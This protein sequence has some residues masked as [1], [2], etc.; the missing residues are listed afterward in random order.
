M[1]KR[2]VV[3]GINDYSRQVP[4]WPDLDFC[5]ADAGAVHHLLLD[6][7]GFDPAGI[8]LLTDQAA[9]SANIRR[10]LAHMIACSEP[11]DVAFFYYSGHG[12]LHPGSTA[13]TYYQ[14]IAPATGR[15]IT[16]WDVAQAVDRLGPSEVNVT[17]MMD[18]CHSG[19]MGDVTPQG[20]AAKTAALTQDALAAV[21][22]SMRKVIPFGIGLADPETLSNNIV[23]VL[24]A[25]GAVACYTEEA[26]REFVTAAKALQYSACRW[27]ETAA[28]DGIVEH[29]YLTKALID[30]VDSCPF[31]ISNVALHS[32]LHAK[33]VQLSGDDQSPVMRGQANRADDTFLAPF[34]DSR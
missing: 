6:S 29:G 15:Y 22:S 28:E 24:E 26:N 3:I 16:D 23:T 25:P 14:S 12:G 5:V 17:V 10:A 31:E 30:T 8:T 33:V 9:S 13:G 34:T 1:T 19:G 21:V 20:P 4:G 7:F 32:S 2:A 18:C 27:D 11:G